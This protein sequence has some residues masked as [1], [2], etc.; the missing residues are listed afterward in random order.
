MSASVLLLLSL[1][2]CLPGLPAQARLSPFTSVPQNQTVSAGSDVVMSCSAGTESVCH[3]VKDGWMVEVGGRFSLKGCDLMISPV[4][5]SDEGEYQCQVGGRQPSV[6]PP[7]S[8]KVDT[9]PGHPH[10]LQGDSLKLDRGDTLQ[11]TCQSEGG[12]PA[13]DLEWWDSLTGRRI[14]SEVTQHVERSG[15]GFKTTSVLSLP[16]NKHMQIYCTAFS[17][18]FPDVKQTSPVEVQIRGEPRLETVQLREG[19][20][21]K[22]FCHNNIQDSNAQFK[23]FI[24]DKLIPDE[25]TDLLEIN[26]FSKSYDKSVV[27]CATGH[28]EIV[29]AVQLEFNPE[30]KAESKIVTLDELMKRKGRQ[31]DIMLGDEQS[32]N[33]PRAMMMKLENPPRRRR[34]LFV[35][36]KMTKKFLESPNMSGSTEN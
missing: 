36:W 35:L 21:V 8:L 15:H 31:N 32:S 2:P 29:R 3:W 18:A 34:H 20:D 27:K 9:A 14:V 6:S 24:N 10:I 5:E 7:A 4:L 30:K 17:E 22:I 13:A 28:D 16:A 1:L 26:Q 23:W 25:T 11:L 33:D 19:E 12:R